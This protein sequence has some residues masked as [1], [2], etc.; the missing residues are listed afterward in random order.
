MKQAYILKLF[1]TSDSW[2]NIYPKPDNKSIKIYIPKKVWGLIDK[3][4][5]FWGKK[6]LLED[7]PAWAHEF[8]DYSNCIDYRF[9]SNNQKEVIFYCNDFQL[10]EL[11]D[12]KPRENSSYIRSSTEPFDDEMAFSLFS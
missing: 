6:M 2:K 4:I 10:Q 12:I 5:D 7:Y 8:L 1:Q 11:I 9:V 3:D